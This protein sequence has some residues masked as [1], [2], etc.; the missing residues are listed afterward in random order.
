ME[1][2]Y[3]KWRELSLNPFSISFQKIQ[4]KEI[5]NYMPAGND[6]LECIFLLGNTKTRLF[7]KIERSKVVDFETEVKHLNLL[8]NEN[9]YKKIPQVIEDGYIGGKKYIVLEKKEGKRLSEIFLE[10]I[11]KEEKDNYLYLYGKE[12]GK[13]HNIKGSKFNKAKQRAINKIPTEENYGKFDANIYPYIERLKNNLLPTEF[14]TFIHGDFH[15][16]NV[17]WKNKKIEAILDFEY[18]GWGCKEQD[19]AWAC[20]L[21]PTQ[22]FMD[23]IEDLTEFVKGYLSENDF[24]FNHFK[25]CLINAYCHFYLMNMNN[26]V[27]TNKILNILDEIIKLDRL[28]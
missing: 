15:Y 8:N 16:A 7:L 28:P 24:V 11:T 6:V 18:S 1:P 27:Y 25:W 23:T 20:V 10:P 17:L 9:V 5:L 19:M 14:T 13:I 4:L 12:L 26:K 3:P 21:R 22:T 2:Q